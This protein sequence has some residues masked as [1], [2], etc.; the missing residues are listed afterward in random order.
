MITWISICF[1]PLQMRKLHVSSALC[2]N[3]SK[4]NSRGLT[5]AG[6]LPSKTR[7]K[8]FGPRAGR[9]PD[10][11]RRRHGAF[12]WLA[13]LQ[14]GRYGHGADPQARKPPAYMPRTRH[15]RFCR[16][17]TRMLLGFYEDNYNGHRGHRTRWRH[18]VVFTAICIYSS[19]MGG[20][21]VCVAFNSTGKERRGS[22]YPCQPFFTNSP[23]GISPQVPPGGS[24]R[25]AGLLPSTHG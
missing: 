19:M 9:K 15:S 22:G 16:G 18:A 11:H 4:P 10:S 12:S 21:A 14:N 5:R 8:S 17:S 13:H 2:R 20:R 7:R 6:S 23:I 24:G 1:G 25:R 3:G